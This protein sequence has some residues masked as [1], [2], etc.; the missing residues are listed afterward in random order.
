MV[1]HRWENTP[2]RDLLYQPTFPL[3]PIR[4]G[5]APC[6][7]AVTGK[8]E[9]DGMLAQG[10]ERVFASEHD[11]PEDAVAIDGVVY[12]LRGWNHPGGDQILLFGGN[13][14]SVQYRMIHPFHA[15]GVVGK[16]P[17]IG[18]LQ[19]YRSVELKLLL[20]S[21]RPLPPSNSL[22]NLHAAGR[23]TRSAPRLRRTSLRPWARS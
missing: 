7:E 16:M 10:G 17:K 18:V 6:A 12:S 23:T 13:D 4:T 3:I 14:V 9:G 20:S 8:P 1:L 5:M 21:H 19:S 22:L 2:T 11:L 15:S